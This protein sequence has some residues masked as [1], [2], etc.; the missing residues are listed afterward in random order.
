MFLG[1]GVRTKVCCTG[2][3]ALGSKLD[4]VSDGK[5]CSESGCYSSCKAVAASVGF[6]EEARERLGFKS[7]TW[8]ENPSLLSFRGDPQGWR[9]GECILFDGLCWIQ[10]AA[11][12]GIET[13]TCLLKNR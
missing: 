8:N 10:M 12:Q 2:R 3:S 9:W 4:R 5:S 7:T 13:D 1:S 6:C 11:D